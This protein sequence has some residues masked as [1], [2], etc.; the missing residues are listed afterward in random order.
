MITI[1]LTK[2]YSTIVDDED[3]DLGC[4]K[5]YSGVV[6][7]GPYAQR[8]APMVGGVRG[9]VMLMHRVI[10][11]RMGI[12]TSQMIDHING[13][14][15]DNRRAN[16]RSASASENARNVSGERANN[17][18]GAMGVHF[19][20]SRSKWMAFI[21]I[22]GAMKNLGRFATL[23]EAQAARLEAERKVWGVQPRRAALHK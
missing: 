12:D 4:L 2:G 18:S 10:A 3:A 15:L 13:N 19:D 11:E 23:E 22:D 8:D 16:L 1:P 20:K 21:R 7:W 6:R 9:K 14:P 17:T 5:W